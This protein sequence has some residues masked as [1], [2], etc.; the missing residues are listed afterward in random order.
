M[1]DEFA[2]EAAFALHRIADVITI[3]EIIN[4]KAKIAV[5]ELAS[6]V[7]VFRVF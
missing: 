5:L 2:I 3:L 6:T 1:R 7:I 4:I